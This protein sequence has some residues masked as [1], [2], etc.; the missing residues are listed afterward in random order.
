[1]KEE[2]GKGKSCLNRQ[3]SQAWLVGGGGEGGWVGGN[4]EMLLMNNANTLSG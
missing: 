4:S 2:E 3:E 1:M